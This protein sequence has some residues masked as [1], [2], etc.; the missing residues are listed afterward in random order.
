MVSKGQLP[1]NPRLVQL[2][3]SE[4]EKIPTAPLHEVSLYFHILTGRIFQKVFN[5]EIA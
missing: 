2:T 1:V 5:L 4:D 3:C